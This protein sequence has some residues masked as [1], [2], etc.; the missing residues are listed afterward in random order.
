MSVLS[1]PEALAQ[2]L[3]CARY[4][5]VA[6]NAVLRMQK[7]SIE[8]V[9]QAVEAT[10]ARRQTAVMQEPGSKGLQSPCWSALTRHCL[11]PEGSPM[12]RGLAGAAIL[13]SGIDAEQYTQPD[14]AVH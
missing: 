6:K 13:Q 10:A 12:M 5:K 3:S 7:H 1:R 9:S 14:V 11:V 2:D 4:Q 8:R